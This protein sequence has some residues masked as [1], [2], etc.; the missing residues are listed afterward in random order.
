MNFWMPIPMRQRRPLS[1]ED[2][3]V[4]EVFEVTATLLNV[5]QSPALNPSNV[6]ATLGLGELVERIGQPSADWLQVQ[7]ARVSGFAAA[8][9]LSRVAVAPAPA[10]AA[11]L[12]IPPQV[13]FLP[14]AQSSLSS[15]EHRHRPLGLQI[16]PRV[17]GQSDAARCADLN[18]IVQRLDVEHSARYQPTTK[19][20]YC[21]I[22]AY[23]YCY[24]AAT[25]LPRVW[26][27]SKALLDLSR[28]IDPGVVYAST[29]RELTANALFD[30]LAEWG[31]EFGWQRCADVNQ[32][33][34]QVNTGTVGVICAQRT[35]GDRT[36]EWRS[37]GRARRP[38]RRDA[39]AESGR[40]K[41][42]SLLRQT[43]VDRPAVS[44]M[45]VLGPA[46]KPRDQ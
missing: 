23:D 33:Q 20:T 40:R 21:N 18:S 1:A 19:S 12:F 17:A 38:D 29:V 10:P 26:W 30:W 31:D 32:L 3:L 35:D 45:R 46:V 11:A 6:I 28:G 16:L 36:G 4:A 13:N 8:R 22:Y 44:R 24:L 43:M 25:Y 9:F 27:M 14:S 15:T 7:N 37:R 41:E 34:Q 5:R 2:L 42:Q 39:A